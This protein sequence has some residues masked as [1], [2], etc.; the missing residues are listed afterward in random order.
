MADP[1][2]ALS[3]PATRCS[4]VL[5]PAPEGPVMDTSVPASKVRSTSRIAGT[6]SPPSTYVREVRF[7]STTGDIGFIDHAPLSRCRRTD[8][9]MRPW[10]TTGR[11][12][13]DRH[14]TRH[15]SRRHAPFGRWLYNLRH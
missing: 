2:V 5:F 7:N 13:A 15:G 3:R 14:S 8:R 9:R 11:Q 1:L 12:V 6:G 10:L 4:R